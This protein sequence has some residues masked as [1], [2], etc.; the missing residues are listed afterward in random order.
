MASLTPTLKDV[1]H[2]GRSKKQDRPPIHAHEKPLTDR[3]DK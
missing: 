2:K 1:V 3:Q